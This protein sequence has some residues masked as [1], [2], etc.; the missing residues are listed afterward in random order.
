MSRPPAHP[1]LV[2][3]DATAADWL[4]RSEDGLTDAERAEFEAWR[5]A[6]PQNRAALERARQAWSALD[7]PRLA[8]RGHEMVRAL[9]TRA[10][11]RRRRRIATVTV[12]LAAVVMFV[13]QWNPRRAA[14]SW[15][16]TARLI[17]PEKRALP[18]GS[19]VELRPGA[20]LTVDYSGEFRRVALRAGEAFF[21][22]AK[23]PA[24][25]FVVSAAG[26]DVRAVGTAF[27][28]AKSSG[29]V[30]V[31]VT[32]GRIAVDHAPAAPPTANAERTERV[33]VNAGHRV[34]MDLAA[35]T[36]VP[37][38]VAMTAAEI[39]ARLDWRAPRVAFTDAA[40]ADAVAIMNRHSV[41]QFVVADAELALLPVNGVFRLGNS[42]AMLRLLEDG[43]GLHA[44]RAGDTITLRKAR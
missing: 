34:T 26:V 25:P 6:D 29:A 36:A 32:E 38:V 28:V 3:V 31:V 43:F 27:T 4:L 40:L 24:R 1:S 5:A 9:R 23:D 20:E 19:V 15:P 2:E 13:L 37:A 22:V 18:D 41:L 14:E 33:Q 21:H 17:V 30:D 16:S 39:A 7:R 10:T 12:A 42:E 35:G 44:Q 11:R 8:G